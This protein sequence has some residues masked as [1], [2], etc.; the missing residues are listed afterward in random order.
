[1]ASVAIDRIVSGGNRMR[2]GEERDRS[3]ERKI[4]KKENRKL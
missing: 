1:M 2:E 4:K 3:R